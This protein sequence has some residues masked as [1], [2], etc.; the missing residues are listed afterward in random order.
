MIVPTT[1][2]MA[3][4]NA[5]QA[6]MPSETNLLMALAEMHKQGRFQ[7]A[8]NVLRMEPKPSNDNKNLQIPDDPQVMGEIDRQWSSMVKAG[9]TP[10][11]KVVPK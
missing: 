5:P 9:N 8:G 4:P 1:P 11:L 6:Q 10:I 2:G 3:G 7:V